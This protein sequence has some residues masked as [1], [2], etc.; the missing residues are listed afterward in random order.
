MDNTMQHLGERWLLLYSI[1][2]NLPFTYENNTLKAEV[3][4]SL[5]KEELE[6]AIS[7]FNLITN[8]SETDQTVITALECLN[9]IK[10]KIGG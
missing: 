3:E 1:V 9:L 7:S 8:L 10:E 6:G 5:T 2:K 4:L